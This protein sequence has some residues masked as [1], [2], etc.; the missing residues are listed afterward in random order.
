MQHEID[1]AVEAFREYTRAFQALDSRAIAGYFHEPA[2][3]IT[4]KEVLALPTAA[5]AEQAFARILAELP[6]DYVRTDFSPVVAHRLGDD[7]AMLSGS[8]SWKNAAD[9]DIMPFGMTYTLR[10]TGGAWRIVVA[11][12]HASDGGP[13]R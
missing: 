11:A 1:G 8:G 9:E 2:V 10:R 6:P 13:G 4:P 3:L 7:L 5:A 12:T